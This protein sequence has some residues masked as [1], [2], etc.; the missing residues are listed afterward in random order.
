MDWISNLFIALLLTN[1]SGTLFYIIGTI[2]R[3]IWFRK[4]VRLIRFS[5]MVVLGAYVLPLV[6]FVLRIQRRFDINQLGNINLFYNTPRTLELFAIMGWV[7]VGLFL[8]LLTYKLYR[9][10]QWTMICNGNIPEEEETV[11][12]CFSDICAE[13][14]IEG[15]V[16]LCR[17]DSVNMPCITYHRGMVVILPLNQY[18]E[19]EVEIILYH[20]LCHY[21]EKDMSLRTLGI[22]IS[23]LHVFNPAVHIMLRHMKLI[24]EMSCDRLVC[25]RAQGRF[26]EQQ[27]FQVIL[28]MLDGGKKRERYQL[29]ALADD[30][31]NYERR[32]A[33]MREYHLSGGFKKC[34]TVMLA[35][36]FLLGSSITSLA[37][38]ARLT[39]A[40]EGYAEATSEWSSQSEIDSID[41]EVVVELART[42]NIDPED[43][44]IMD[45]VNMEGRG[46]TVHFEWNVRAGKTYVSTGFSEEIGDEVSIFVVGDPVD[47]TFWTGLKDPD[48][49]MNY[50]EG[51]DIVDHTF[52]IE[53]KG[54]YYFFVKNLSETEDLF[55]DATIVK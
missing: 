31:S 3:K 19:E 13:F 53:I 28:N 18:T 40:Y 2:F 49:I 41:Q 38:G 12:R 42:Y 37:A 48:N 47:L 25:E 21:L 30:R 54:R 36:C 46:R 22:I 39:G 11:K 52:A 17:N 55:I 29:F 4:D 1:I 32:V 20:E 14:G 10:H 43:I 44:V 8:V 15:K 24:C 34:A 35:T 9:R 27:Y 51:N 7:W 50:V 26:S 5:T 45:N 16:S 23:L 6:Y 33:A